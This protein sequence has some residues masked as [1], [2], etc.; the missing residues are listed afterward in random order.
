ME[1]PEKIKIELP[2][3]ATILLDIYPEPGNTNS[4][5]Y[6]HSRGYLRLMYGSSDTATT[7]VSS[8]GGIDK[9]G[10]CTRVH[11]HTRTKE[12]NTVRPQLYV[13]TT[14]KQVHKYGERIDNW[15]IT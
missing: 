14:N 15:Q 6:I 1:G 2:T 8:N 7:Q 9:E 4:K 13:E 3:D 10:M 12:K 11:T 5:G